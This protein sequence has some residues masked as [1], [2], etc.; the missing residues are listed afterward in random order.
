MLVDHFIKKCKK[1]FNKNITGIT[2]NVE[3][4]FMEYP[5]PGNVRELEHTME[6]AFIHCN[7]RTITHKHLPPCFMELINS[8]V[9]SSEDLEIDQTQEIIQALKKTAGNKSKAAELLGVSRRNLYRKM[10][11][12]NIDG[13]EFL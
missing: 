5:W 12:L 10:K 13:I 6:H 11:E 1:T 9:E 7:Q 4:I 8:K 3:E 2:L